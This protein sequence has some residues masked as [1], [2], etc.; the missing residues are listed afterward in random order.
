MIPALSAHAE[1]KTINVPH[2]PTGQHAL[3]EKSGSPQ[4]RVVVT[5]RE[6]LLGVIYSSASTTAPITQ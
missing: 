4:A 2:D 5:R 6:G 3:V 1:A